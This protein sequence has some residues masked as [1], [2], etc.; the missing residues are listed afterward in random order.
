[1]T[2][3]FSIVG[4]YVVTSDPHFFTFFQFSL[5]GFDIMSSYINHDSRQHCEVNKV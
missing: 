5:M 1:M 4:S 2:L 3:I